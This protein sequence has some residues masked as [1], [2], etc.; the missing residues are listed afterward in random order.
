[1]N[2][3]MLPP[4]VALEH[5]VSCSNCYPDARQR[6]KDTLE[7]HDGYVPVGELRELIDEWR[8]TKVESAESEYTPGWLD[9]AADDLEALIEGD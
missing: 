8:A 4:A 9:K 6:A 7:A 2:G 3:D 1:M 5:M